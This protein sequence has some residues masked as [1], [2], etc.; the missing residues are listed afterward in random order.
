MTRTSGLNCGFPT[1][2][3]VFRIR[4]G[5]RL[6]DGDRPFKSSGV[7]VKS[8]RSESLHNPGNLMTTLFTRQE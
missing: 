1:P 8:F 2:T 7:P 6:L 4:P 5:P 3:Y